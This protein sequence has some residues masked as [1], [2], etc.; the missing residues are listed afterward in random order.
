MAVLEV[1]DLHMSFGGVKALSGVDLVLNEGEILAIIGPNGAGKTT[2]I[3]CISGWYRPQ[4]G[5]ILLEG[6]EITGLPADRVAALGLA[7]TF[8][9]TALFRGMTVLENIMS[10]A[11]VYMRSNFLSCGIYW[12]LAQKEELRVREIAEDIIDFLEIEHI[13]KVPAGALP[14]GLRRRV[15]LGRA[16]AMRPKV[17]LLDEPMAGLNVEEKEDMARFILDVNEE[18]GLPVILIDHDMGVVMDISHRVMVL[19][20]GAKIAEGGPEDVRQ[21]PL[22][23]SAYLGTQQEALR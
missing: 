19:D 12:G 17:L 20:Q 21:N 18:R 10:G 2:L 14:M 23:I 9:N 15:E 6:K 11:H 22:V 16:L 13:R 4:A 3:N 7:R 1:H 8:Q 5:R